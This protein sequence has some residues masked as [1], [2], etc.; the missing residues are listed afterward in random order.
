MQVTL[1][2]ESVA[3]V[4]GGHTTVMDDYQGGVVSIIR[5]HEELP[6]ETLKG[7][8]KFSH[9]Q[10]LWHFHLGSP[11]DVALHAR[12]P[13]NNPAWEPSGTF[14]HRNHRRPN[15]LAVSQPRLVRTDGHDLY[16]T[17]LDAVDGTPIF[18][19]AGWFPVMGPRGPVHAPKWVSELIEPDYWADADER[20]IRG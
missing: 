20:P 1:E 16:V 11:D 14:A 4:V 13:R 9:L 19:F 12:S 5:V 15:R 8:E 6:V 7:L 18:D 17:D 2:I 10:V 3:T